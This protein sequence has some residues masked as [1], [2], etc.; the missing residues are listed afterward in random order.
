MKDFDSAV[1]DQIATPGGRVD[2]NK[3]LASLV[4]RGDAVLAFDWLSSGE[5]LTQQV[6]EFHH[7]G[8]NPPNDLIVR[9]LHCAYG[10]MEYEDREKFRESYTLE[11]WIMQK[12][13]YRAP[14]AA[15]PARG[16]LFPLLPDESPIQPGRLTMERYIA[17][18]MD[19]T[20]RI[21]GQPVQVKKLRFLPF[22]SGLMDRAIQ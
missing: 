15:I 21:V 5:C 9:S 7:N 16:V 11:F 13:M 19:F 1:K 4:D 22:L 17:P 2:I 18:L 10:T 8:L 20:I 6:Y 12:V 3:V 14:L